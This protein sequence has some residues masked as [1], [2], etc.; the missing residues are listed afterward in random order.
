[1]IVYRIKGNTMYD[2]EI[3]IVINNKIEKSSS[4][5]ILNSGVC[6]LPI[7]LGRITQIV[8]LG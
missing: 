6:Y 8:P 1:M 3:N 2:K 5:Y 7:L 4:A